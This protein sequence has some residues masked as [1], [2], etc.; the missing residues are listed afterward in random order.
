MPTYQESVLVNIAVYS[1]SYYY[2]NIIAG[3]NGC[4]EVGFGCLRS[5]MK[6]SN[7][8]RLAAEISARSDARA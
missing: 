2:W 3:G 7:S 6:L 1:W 5:C 4:R 8:G